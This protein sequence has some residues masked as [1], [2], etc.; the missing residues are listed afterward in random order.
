[1]G[2]G[3]PNFLNLDTMDTT[4][5]DRRVNWLHI[6]LYGLVAALP[7]IVAN[8]IYVYMIGEPMSDAYELRFDVEYMTR[9][10][11]FIFM[12]IGF[13]SYTGIAFWIAKPNRTRTL[14]NGARLVLVGHLF[15]ILFLFLMGVTYKIAYLFAPATYMVGIVIAAFTPLLLKGRQT[16]AKDWDARKDP[17]YDKKT[18]S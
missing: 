10:G 13:L 3:T 8:L 15:E 12:T 11:I 17:N 9:I 4:L 2:R 16:H 14:Y 6:I 7:G 5:E 18:R 1:M